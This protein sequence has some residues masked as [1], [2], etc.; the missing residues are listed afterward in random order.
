M[1]VKIGKEHPNLVQKLAQYAGS[2]TTNIPSVTPS[3]LA[4]FVANFCF[5][6]I[7]DSHLDANTLSE[8]QA[9]ESRLAKKKS[10]AELT[11]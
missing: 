2:K 6:N 4:G 7:P 8:V 9:E 5:L 3:S 11:M 1:Y 10:E